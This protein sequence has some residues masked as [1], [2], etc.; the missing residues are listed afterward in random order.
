MET[1]IFT[2]EESSPLNPGFGKLINQLEL[3]VIDFS[4]NFN[5]DLHKLVS[6]GRVGAFETGNAIAFHPDFCTALRSGRDLDP[7]KRTFDRRDLDAAPQNGLREGDQFFDVDVVSVPGE[8][9]M[10]ENSDVQIEVAGRAAL[11]PGVSLA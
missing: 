4:G 1:R 7:L 10:R 11:Y 9:R 5:A 6:F 3:L 8:D 2:V